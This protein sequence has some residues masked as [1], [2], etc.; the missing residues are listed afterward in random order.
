MVEDAIITPKV[1]KIEIAGKL[2]GTFDEI[3]TEIS[4]L[5]FYST[6]TSQDSISIGLVE[7]RNI[8]K[9]PY[10][11]YIFEIKIDKVSIIYS[12]PN[13]ISESM[14]RAFVMRNFSSLMSIIS[15]VY[16]LSQQEFTQY[17]DSTTD[18]LLSGLSENYSILFNKY[19]ALLTEYRAVKRL[20]IELSAS[21]RNLTLESSQLLEDNKK[22]KQE[23]DKLQ[24]YSDESLMSIVEDWITVHGSSIDIDEFAKNYNIP[25]P[26]V[27]EILDKMVSKGYIELRE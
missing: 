6:F 22:L 9:Q 13:D 21:N 27:E 16:E 25:P 8:H 14:R 26:R 23:L 7:S 3:A 18:K 10:L 20:N 17:V 24:K 12:I 1:E 4:K 2:K 11:F 19:D 5:P 15:D